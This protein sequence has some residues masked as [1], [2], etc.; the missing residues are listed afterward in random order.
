[1]AKVLL[2]TTG[3][4]M[5]ISGGQE[6]S[7]DRPSV[8]KTSYFFEAR[9]AK[10]ELKVLGSVVDEATD[11]EFETFV[12][13]SK[14]DLALAVESFLSKFGVNKITTKGDEGGEEPQAKR[15]GK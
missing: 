7:P 8:I 3:S 4:F 14:G 11:A 10:G 5:L 15:K 13:E 2:E 6:V 12:R 9:V 1:M